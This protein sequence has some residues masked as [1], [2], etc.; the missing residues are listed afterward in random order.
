MTAPACEEEMSKTSGFAG[1]QL[2]GAYNL[3]IS[4]NVA[5]TLPPFKGF[6]CGPVKTFGR[7]LFRFFDTDQEG[8][9]SKV[10]AAKVQKTACQGNRLSARAPARRG[11]HNGAH[12]TSAYHPGL[13]AP[14]FFFR[15]VSSARPSV[16]VS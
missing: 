11:R 13:N 14:V 6:E 9:G 4:G 16:Q 1:V 5:I 10:S 15:A 8:N 3:K 7:Y 12:R 2:V